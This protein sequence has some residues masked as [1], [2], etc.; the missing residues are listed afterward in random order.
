[1][2]PALRASLVSRNVCRKSPFRT[3]AMAEAYQTLQT[4]QPQPHTLQVTLNRP[5][6]A[7]AMNT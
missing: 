5:E 4:T 6:S 7:N 1:M 3:H 2:R